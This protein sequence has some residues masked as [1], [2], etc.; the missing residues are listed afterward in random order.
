MAQ[1]FDLSKW[2]SPAIKIKDYDSGNSMEIG[3][4]KGNVSLQVRDTNFKTLMRV[5]LSKPKFREIVSIFK[6]AIQLSPGQKLDLRVR[7][8]IPAEPKGSFQDDWMFEIVKDEE[9]VYKIVLTTMLEG[10]NKFTFNVS[11]PGGMSRN[12]NDFTKSEKSMSMLKTMLW[13]LT[14]IFPSG[15]MLSTQ[16]YE[17]PAGGGGYNNNSGG[18]NNY[19]P[20]APASGGTGDMPY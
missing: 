7:K 14:E 3:M 10:T 18:G 17:K 6:E 1:S 8:W 9:Q 20:A 11:A 15:I 13:E 2:K 12:G 19:K 5:P 16:Q 4:W